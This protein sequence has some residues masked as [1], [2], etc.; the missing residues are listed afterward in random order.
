VVGD[1]VAIG[2][3]AILLSGIVVGDD[4]TIGAG[5]L[6]TRDVPAGA[7]MRGA[8]AKPITVEG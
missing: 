5:A 4:A 3:G 6:V 2:A 8:P 1:R 7:H